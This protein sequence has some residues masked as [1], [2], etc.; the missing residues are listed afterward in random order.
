MASISLREGSL[1]P[2]VSKSRVDL[3]EMMYV[4]FR[5]G[6]D[7]HPTV[8]APLRLVLCWAGPVMPQ[9]LWAHGAEVP[10]AEV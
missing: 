8:G 4:G 2:Y 10:G 5:G 6:C 1:G 9:A 7:G 3:P